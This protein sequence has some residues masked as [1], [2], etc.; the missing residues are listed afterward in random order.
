MTYIIC[1]IINMLITYMNEKMNGCICLYPNGFLSSHR[2][3]M[4]HQ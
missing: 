3:F 2:V 1:I 4:L